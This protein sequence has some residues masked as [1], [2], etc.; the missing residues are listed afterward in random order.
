MGISKR[1]K[2]IA[3]LVTKGNV[4]A[5]IG[6]DHGY[7]PI[8]LLREKISPRAIAVDVSKG[9]L[10]KAR[11]NAEFFHLKIQDNERIANESKKSK[12]CES[13]EKNEQNI[14][15]IIN[16]QSQD[17]VEFEAGGTLDNSIIQGNRKI[18]NIGTIDLRL[19]DGLSV[20]KSGEADTIIISGMGGILMTNILEA[21]KEVSLSAKELILSPHRDADLVRGF[22][23]DYGFKIVFDEVITDKKKSYSIIKGVKI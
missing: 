4:A 17:D 1:L 12:V 18:N 10:E 6:T 2:L 21:H 20:L 14:D 22:L 15:E 19:G 16:F 8:Y 13:E 23:N 3:E 9:S 11:E 7:V 5:D